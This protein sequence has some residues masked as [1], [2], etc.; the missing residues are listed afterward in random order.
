MLWM[1]VP[2]AAAPGE[3]PRELRFTVCRKILAGLSVNEIEQN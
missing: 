1:I 2:G 3:L